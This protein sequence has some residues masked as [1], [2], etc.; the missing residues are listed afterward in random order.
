MKKKEASSFQENIRSMFIAYSIVP[1]FIFTCLTLL[2]IVVIRRYSV[3]LSTKKVNQEFCD[4]LSDMIDNYLLAL[5]D[6]MKETEGK[7]NNSDIY[8]ELYKLNIDNGIESSFYILDKEQN[9]LF[10]FGE[11]VPDI[12]VLP[13]YK[14]WGIL[15]Q[16][17]NNPG[18]NYVTVQDGKL[19]IGNATGNARDRKYLI[20]TV[21]KSNIKQ[22]MDVNA[23]N[24]QMIVTDAMGWV[25]YSNQEFFID[26][27]NRLVSEIKNAN[28]IINYQG[29]KFCVKQMTLGKYD[30]KA[31]TISVMQMNIDVI[32]L[33]LIVIVVIFTMLCVITYFSTKRMALKYSRDIDDIANAFES[34]QNGVLDITLNI[35]SSKEFQAIGRDFNM[36][37][38]GLKQ[39]IE[40]NKE[41]AEHVAFAQV[42]Q[43]ESQFNPHFLFNTLDNI[44]FMTKIDIKAADKMIVSLS[45]LLRY[46]IRDTRD[47]LTV[48][49]DFENLQ[50]YLNIL[51]IRFNKRFSY[52][53]K[54]EDEIMSCLIP[55]LLIQPL[56]ENS[57]KY[58]FADCDSLHVKIFGYRKDNSVVFQCEDNG[59]GMDETLLAELRSQLHEERNTTSHSGLYNI[60]RRIHLLYKEDYGMTI[61]SK[62]NKGTIITLKLPYLI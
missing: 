21:P 58:G 9:V 39:Q 49:E 37:T 12:F 44:R 24:R 22:I 17:K 35:N 61:E 28:G 26:E 43:L 5:D 34:V 19:C 45:K 23:A 7:T 59:I 55:K 38:R 41:M 4:E 27:M 3:E 20:F 18:I 11:D 60:H 52:E 33:L 13:E 42:K 36:M 53:I 47:V 62:M 56:I 57:I 29:E 2:L 10:E 50:S 8:R 25:Y 46:S 54:I 6:I 14:D 30:I 40:Q 48:K 51:Q 15:K 31:I 16:I 32:L 1:V